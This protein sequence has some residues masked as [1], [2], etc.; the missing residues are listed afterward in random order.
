MMPRSTLF[1]AGRTGLRYKIW[2]ELIKASSSLAT[3]RNDG[4]Q[5]SDHTIYA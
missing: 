5:M 2:S 4:E 1:F 3:N